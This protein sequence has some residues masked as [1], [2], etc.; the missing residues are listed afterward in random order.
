M[1][2]FVL[3]RLVSLCLAA[4]TAAAAYADDPY[5]WIVASTLGLSSDT[6][7][8][9]AVEASVDNGLTASYAAIAY[10]EYNCI[11][12]RY[13]DFGYLY[14]S[15]PKGIN[16]IEI[17]FS[18]AAAASKDGILGI[19]GKKMPYD[20]EKYLKEG[21]D[22]DEQKIKTGIA[23]QNPAYGNGYI[24][25]QIGGLKYVRI[26][27]EN[28]TSYISSLRV[29]FDEA[30]V[31]EDAQLVNETVDGMGDFELLNDQRLTFTVSDDNDDRDATGYEL[32][33]NDETMGDVLPDANGK[34]TVCHFPPYIDGCE[35][36]LRGKYTLDGITQTAD[37]QPVSVA[38]PQMATT[39]HAISLVS[40]EAYKL[41]DDIS[42]W[43]VCAKV[44]FIYSLTSTSSETAAYITE[45]AFTSDGCGDDGHAGLQSAHI[46]A[47]DGRNVVATG[48]DSRFAV[49]YSHLACNSDGIFGD[50]GLSTTFTLS[51][52][53]LIA[54]PQPSAQDEAAA[55]QSDETTLVATVAQTLSIATITLRQASI[56]LGTDD[57][58]CHDAYD[59]P[60]YRNIQGI[61]LPHRPTTPGIYIRRQNGIT[62]K[63]IVR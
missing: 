62:S 48:S 11:A 1:C 6:S 19:Y 53:F 50:I 8:T 16:R 46:V 22:P 7:Q 29:Y 9:I 24:T 34:V 15:S 45:A 10:Q 47:D 37:S 63:F 13:F 21:G 2:K 27:A 44:I 31:I 3:S 38:A 17:K 23:A 59:T 36:K 54:D 40:A 4:M 20:N 61:P 28:K 39:E 14:I 42:G 30:P 18:E 52:P 32:L 35:I 60:T 5:D 57:P 25:V 41:P 58:T 12:L 55:G 26:A 49:E 43:Q 51:Y 56:T 33:V